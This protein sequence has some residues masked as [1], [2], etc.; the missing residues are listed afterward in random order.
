MLG[1]G[2]SIFNSLFALSDTKLCIYYTHRALL[3]DNI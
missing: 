1:F 2:G 3:V